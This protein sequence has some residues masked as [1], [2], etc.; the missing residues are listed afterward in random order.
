[1]K[2]YAFKAMDGYLWLISALEAHP[3]RVFWLGLAALF[4]TA[5]WL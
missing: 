5:S 4:A 1:M 2:D 3:H